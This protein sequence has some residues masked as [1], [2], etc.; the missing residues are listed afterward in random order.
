MRVNEG[1]QRPKWA[2]NPA[3]TVVGGADV[4]AGALTPTQAESG[5]WYGSQDRG[6]LAGNGA[7]DGRGQEGTS[8]QWAMFPSL[9]GG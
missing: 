3:R 9:P 6:C 7:G 4:P 8:A 2:G 5:P 1:Q